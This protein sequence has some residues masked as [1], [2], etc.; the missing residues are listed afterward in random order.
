MILS[1]LSIN[2]KSGTINNNGKQICQ[3][4]MYANTCDLLISIE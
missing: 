4:V 1:P 3:F 2:G